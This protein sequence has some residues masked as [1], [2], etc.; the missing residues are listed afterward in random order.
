MLYGIIA[1]VLGLGAMFLGKKMKAFS[2]KQAQQYEERKR[3]KAEEKEK[4]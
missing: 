4:K 2:E 3:Q 1:V